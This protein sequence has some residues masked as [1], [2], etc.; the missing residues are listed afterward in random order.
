MLKRRWTDFN[1]QRW[2]IDFK[3][4][5][6]QI[7]QRW[8]SNVTICTRPEKA[9]TRK[10]SKQASKLSSEERIKSHPNWGALVFDGC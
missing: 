10:A 2:Q 1:S 5:G 4:T 6:F 9:K 8:M 7:Q 3:E